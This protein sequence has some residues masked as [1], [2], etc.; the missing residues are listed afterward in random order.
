MRG[1]IMK[2]NFYY[3]LQCGAF[4]RFKDNEQ[5]MGESGRRCEWNTVPVVIDEENNDRFY[6]VEDP[7]QRWQQ[8][9]FID[10]SHLT[11]D[12]EW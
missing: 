6:F 8:Y 1:E 7:F 4:A 11:N 10:L 3:C 5:C 9:P 2:R 12:E